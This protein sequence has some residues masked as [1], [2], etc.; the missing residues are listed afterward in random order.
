MI[1]KNKNVQSCDKNSAD[2]LSGIFSYPNKF[3]T[4][5]LPIHCCGYDTPEAKLD[6]YLKSLKFKILNYTYIF[7][8]TFIYL[9]SRYR[10][11]KTYFSYL[12]E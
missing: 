8:K 1:E 4:S 3:R 10:S 9:N 11:F 2:V 6:L 7:L 5:F 12:V